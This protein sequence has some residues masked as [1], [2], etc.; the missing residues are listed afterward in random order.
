M[1]P[2]KSI[3]SR[4]LPPF[5]TSFIFFES[6]FPSLDVNTILKLFTGITC[7]TVDGTVNP[8][9]AGL[10]SVTFDSAPGSGAFVFLKLAFRKTI[11]KFRP[12]KGDD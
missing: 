3:F 8:I 11:S 7:S 12:L 5:G 6:S 1:Y 9:A 2:F 10:S 4:I